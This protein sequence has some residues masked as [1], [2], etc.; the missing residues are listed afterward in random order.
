MIG[1]LKRELRDLA[2]NEPNL[3]FDILNGRM[4]PRDAPAGQL[5]AQEVIQR[6]ARTRM[7]A[8][9]LHF[10]VVYSSAGAQITAGILKP[11]LGSLLI[12][13]IANATTTSG[14][15]RVIANLHRPR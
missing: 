7:S 14:S 6:V 10:V 11:F 8:E 12:P 9:L 5:S 1:I 4:T 3:S 13:L 15:A 2:G